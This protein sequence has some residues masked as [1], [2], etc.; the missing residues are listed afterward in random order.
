MENKIPQQWV[1]K[2]IQ[3][4]LTKKTLLKKLKHT[5]MIKHFKIKLK[6]VMKLPFQKV[7]KVKG[8]I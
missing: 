4:T 5:I 8:Q 3:Q 1:I 2:F 6:S 7:V